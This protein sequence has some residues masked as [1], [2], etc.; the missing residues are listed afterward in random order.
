MYDAK[1]SVYLGLNSKIL[2]YECSFCSSIF[3]LLFADFVHYS[4]VYFQ[5]GDKIIILQTD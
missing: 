3:E 4:L 1:V 2:L 5:S